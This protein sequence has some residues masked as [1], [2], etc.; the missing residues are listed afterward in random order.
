MDAEPTPSPMPAPIPAKIE[1][2][3]IPACPPVAVIPTIEIPTVDGLK[4]LYN[5]FAHVDSTNTTY[6]IDDKH[7]IIIIWAGPVEIDDYDYENNP[8]GLRS[9][10]VWDFKNNRIVRFNKTGQYLIVSGDTL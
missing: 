1:Q 10:E 9:Q 4:T 6:Y 5:C 7:R 2:G 8:L 3:I